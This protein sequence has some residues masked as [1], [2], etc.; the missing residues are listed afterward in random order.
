MPDRVGPG[1]TDRVGR[2]ERRVRRS[3]IRRAS[4]AR[5]EHREQRDEQT[6]D[7]DHEDGAERVRRIESSHAR[8]VPSRISASPISWLSSVIRIAVQRPSR[9]IINAVTRQ[10]EPAAEGLRGQRR[11]VPRPVLDHRRRRQQQDE[12]DRQLRAADDEQ[13]RAH[14]G[15]QRRLARLGGPRI[16]RAVAP[17]RQR[18]EHR[19]DDV[20]HDPDPERDVRR[21]EE[22]EMV[23]RPDRHEER[24]RGHGQESDVDPMPVRLERDAHEEVRPR[25]SR[26]P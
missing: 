8:V 22:V 21:R 17:P 10:R 2:L 19:R 4:M 6:G 25:C 1:L 13:Q 14:E 24:E 18:D 12:C 3:S 23:E 5:F 9:P 20:Q 16:G 11:Q 15:G 26:R 7:A